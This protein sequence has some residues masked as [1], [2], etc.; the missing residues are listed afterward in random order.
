M[1]VIDE[2]LR[3]FSSAD[4][5]SLQRIRELILATAPGAVEVMTYGMPGFKYKNK[6]LISFAAFKDHLSIFPGAQVVADF[7]DDIA[8]FKTSKGTIQ[9]TPNNPLPDDLV[10]AIVKRRVQEIET[11][12]QRKQ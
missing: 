4:R 12:A 1:S 9:F 10:V 8:G 3:D 2:L 11:S 6:Y 5:E 7:K